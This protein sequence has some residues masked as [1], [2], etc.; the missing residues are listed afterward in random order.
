[1][2][3]SLLALLLTAALLLALSPAHATDKEELRR[4]L[5]EHS[6]RALGY[7]GEAW[8][9]N[10]LTARLGA[11]PL[12]LLDYLRTDNELNGFPGIPEA[13][14][15]T[16]EFTTALH[17][18]FAALPA[19]VQR[20]FTTRLIGIFLVTKLGSTGF[21]ESVRDASGQERFAFIVLDRDELI[22]RT[23]NSWATWKE[24]TVFAPDTPGPAVRVLIESGPDDTT[25]NAIR[26]ILLHEFG[27]AAGLLSKAVPPWSVDLNAISLLAYPFTLLSWSQA[28]GVVQS[29]FEEMFP[30]RGIITFYQPERGLARERALAVYAG[31]QRTNYPSLQAA[32]NLQEDFA[33]SF[34][35][36]IHVVREK[37]PWQVLLEPEDAA[38]IPVTSCWRTN[39]CREKARYMEKWFANPMAPRYQSR[40]LPL[41]G[42][43]D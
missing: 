9:K 26:F 19:P 6:I 38:P 23:A 2:F 16:P 37:R 34:A 35:T 14:A 11:A 1:M 33:E 15:P 30:E 22:S 10:E 24:N 40:L 31:L 20:L 17:Q 43:E 13:A 39:R 32:V 36:Y 12:A 41:D 5:A 25:V 42:P 21:C 3:R 4:Q 8:N 7:W 18:T 27:H 29:R 28:V